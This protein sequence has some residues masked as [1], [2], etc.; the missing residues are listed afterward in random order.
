VVGDAFEEDVDAG[1]EEDVPGLLAV[2]QRARLREHEM[3]VGAGEQH[4]AG[5]RLLAVLRHADGAACAVPKPLREPG[6]EGHVDML[7]DDDCG[8]PVVGQRE[9]EVGDRLG[10]AG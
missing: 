6:C 9:E 8:V 10:A 7:H 3:V 1:P 4:V 2:F 5:K